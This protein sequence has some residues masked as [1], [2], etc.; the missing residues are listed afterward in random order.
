[1]AFSFTLVVFGSVS[2]IAAI[3][4]LMSRSPLVHAVASGAS[5]AAS[6][7][8]EAIPGIVGPS[9][10]SGEEGGDS[11]ASAGEA[12]GEPAASKA[13]GET[14]ADGSS[15][16]GEGSG[17][18]GGSSG[19]GA[20]SKSPDAQS[21][22]AGSDA[23][24][25]GSP[26]SGESAGQD[27]SSGGSE[28]SDAE[29][30]AFR[31]QLQAYLDALDST[32]YQQTVD[33]YNEFWNLRFAQRSTRAAAMD[34]MNACL[35]N[36]DADGL[37]VQMLDVPRGSSYTD[38]WNRIVD[39]YADLSGTLHCVYR[40][41]DDGMQYESMYGQQPSEQNASAWMGAVTGNMVGGQD[42]GLADYQRLRSQVSL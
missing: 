4:S 13:Q 3:P 7:V 6:A 27:P 41:W 22:S 2:Y 26:S 21:G 34:R 16:A 11:D 20:A 30:Q 14:G 17:S 42:Q 10:E 25:G 36:V 5:E 24:F 19:S 38:E 28:E 39:M 1:M 15:A 12:A 9:G 18:S 33:S 35:R 29:D 32:Y 23:G 8:S 40:S 37:Q 31:S